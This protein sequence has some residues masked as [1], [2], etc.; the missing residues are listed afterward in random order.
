[1]FLSAKNKNSLKFFESEYCNSC[2]IR[3]EKE[4]HVCRALE[5]EKLDSCLDKC[6]FDESCD[7]ECFAVFNINNKVSITRFLMHIY[8]LH[9]R[10]LL[11]SRQ[12]AVKDF[13]SRFGFSFLVEVK[14]NSDWSICCRPIQIMINSD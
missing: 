8:L 14:F 6:A 13:N 3:Y 10:S 2:E 1:M 4:N 7:T 5:K 9:T 12:K 11:L